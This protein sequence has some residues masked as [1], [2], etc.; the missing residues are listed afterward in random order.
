MDIKSLWMTET[1]IPEVSGASCSTLHFGA[2][3][4]DGLLVPT[5]P[6]LGFME[7]IYQP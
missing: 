3:S 6:L 1:L 5:S 7:K 4:A 2:D